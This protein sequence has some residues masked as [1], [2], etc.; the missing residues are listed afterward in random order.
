MIEVRFYLTADERDPVAEWLAKLRDMKAKTAIVRRIIRLEQG[1]F[2][3]WKPCRD[4]V[5]ELRIDV[6][7]GY[8]VYYAHVGQTIVLLLCGGD[9]RTQTAD[10]DRAVTYWRDWQS[11][12][13]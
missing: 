13:E 8:R 9:K 1:N 4:G 12:E 11:R 5:F 10:I 2:G 6:G 7:Q 3:D